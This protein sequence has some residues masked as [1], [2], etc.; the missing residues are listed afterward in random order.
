[1]KYLVKDKK[2]TKKT[3]DFLDPRMD[4]LIRMSSSLDPDQAQHFVRPGLTS[5]CLQEV[6]SAG[7]TVR[8][9]VKV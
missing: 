7:N 3:S 2:Q 1:M 8:Q 5:N 4:N 6:L 9:R